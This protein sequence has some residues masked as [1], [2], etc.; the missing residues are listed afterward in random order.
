MN[1]LKLVTAFVLITS[2]IFIGSSLSV[3]AGEKVTDDEEIKIEHKQV[4]KQKADEKLKE[5][6][7]EKAPPKAVQK[8]A[9]SEEVADAEEDSDEEDSATE[10]VKNTK[11]VEKVPEN[12]GEASPK[13]S[14]FIIT[15][16]SEYQNLWNSV[17][18]KIDSI[19]TAEEDNDRLR[20]ENSNL[21]VMLES[22]HY[23][24]SMEA[25]KQATQKTGNKLSAETGTR[26]GRTLASIS[27][28]FPEN[29]L[30]D[31]LYTLGVSYFKARDNEK[32]VSIFSFL[33]ELKDDDSY[34]TP[35]NYLMTGVAW[36][37]LENYKEADEYFEKV[38]LMSKGKADLA[39]WLVQANIWKALVA[40]KNHAPQEA[41]VWLKK[42]LET[43]PQAVEAR[44][45]NPQEGSRF[46]AAAQESH[47]EHSKTNR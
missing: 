5:K 7:A 2:C 22:R 4:A 46:P 42:T 26:V 14:N 43:H 25:A 12:K 34:K 45:I 15:L 31:A 6:S 44:W 16:L 33:T 17:Q 39:K 27:Y 30:P 20:L 13:R 40:E 36:Y 37:R 1:Q 21:R 47:D 23:E 11:D 24:C 3:L 18:S 38:Q 35:A 41:Q 29:M 32:A 9:P 28:R 19:R 8:E 10:V